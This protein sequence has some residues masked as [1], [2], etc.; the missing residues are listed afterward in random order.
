MFYPPLLLIFSFE[1]D[2]SCFK[3]FIACLIFPA[4]YTHIGRAL[5][6]MLA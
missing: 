3:Y 4:G 6:I 2:N 5:I 1:I